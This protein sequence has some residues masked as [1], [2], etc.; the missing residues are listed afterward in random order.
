VSPLINDRAVD[1]NTPDVIKP[2]T[3]HSGQTLF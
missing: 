1:R 2:Y 3:Y